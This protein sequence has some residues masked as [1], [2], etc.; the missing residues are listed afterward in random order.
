MSKSYALSDAGNPTFVK[1][2][3]PWMDVRCMDSRL[4][5]YSLW[6]EVLPF[7]SSY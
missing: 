1:H 3:R 4:R 5:R 6:R 7:Q 2:Q